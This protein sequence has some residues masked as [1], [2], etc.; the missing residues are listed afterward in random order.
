MVLPASIGYVLLARP[1]VAALLSRGSFRGAAPQ[2]TADVLACFAVGLLGFALFIPLY[3]T[4][5]D[6]AVSR[7]G[8]RNWK[9]V[10]RLVYLAYL[11]STLHYVRINPDLFWNISKALLMMVS[12]A[13]YGLELAA[14]AKYMMKRRTI[15]NTLYGGAL[16]AFGIILLYLA[17][18]R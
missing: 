2:L 10:H 8:V 7:L 14:Y 1:L 12:V 3:I 11:F 13:A 6:W 9:T 17:F 15:G 16:I 4:S 5:T 18:Q